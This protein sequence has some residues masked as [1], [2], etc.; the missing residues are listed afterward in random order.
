MVSICLL[1]LLDLKIFPAIQQLE[2][3]WIKCEL[4]EFQRNVNQMDSVP[5]WFRLFINELIKA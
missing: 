5:S 1:V 3:N 4:I 2:I